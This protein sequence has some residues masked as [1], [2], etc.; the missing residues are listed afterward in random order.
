MAN[1]AE[2]SSIARYLYAIVPST[3][4]DGVPLVIDVPGL[5][6]TALSMV[7]Y[8]DIGIITHACPPHL[9]EGDVAQVHARVLAQHQVIS[10]AHSL[11]G[12]ILPIR[13]NSIVTPTAEQPAVEL[14]V[15]WLA[16]E[17]DEIVTRLDGLRNR[18]ELG[19]QVISVPPP[20]E[21]AATG[22]EA[23]RGRDYFK[24][25]L[26]QRKEKERARATEALTAQA[27]FDHLAELSD[28]VVINSKRPQREGTP[29]AVDEVPGGRLQLDVALLVEPDKVSE[30]GRYL[31]ELETTPGLH[32]RFTGPWAPYAFAGALGL[33]LLVTDNPA[34][35]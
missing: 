33:P 32:V 12:T 26:A 13:F 3:G 10:A 31:G 9:Y 1:Q 18:V 4:I 15:A 23:P 19:V 21:A 6:G 20:T 24:A 14:L 2:A 25:Q 7:T 34:V 11:A 5:D 8:R 29:T 27:I 17:H 35:D 22:A 30:V 16:R 28:R